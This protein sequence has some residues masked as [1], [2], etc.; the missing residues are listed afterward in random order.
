MSNKRPQIKDVTLGIEFPNGTRKDILINAEELEGVFWSDRTV[1]EMLAQFYDSNDK[2]ATLSELK[3]SFG[4]NAVSGVV[5][6]KNGNVKLTSSL[7]KNIWN[8]VNE[9]GQKPVCILKPRK[10]IPQGID[11]NA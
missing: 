2:E 6:D 11:M 4:E 10:C 5:A 3:S 9:D 7:I 8:S 1:I